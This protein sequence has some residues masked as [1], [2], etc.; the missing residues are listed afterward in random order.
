MTDCFPRSNIVRQTRLPIYSIFRL[1]FSHTRPTLLDHA[2]AYLRDH[3]FARQP[4]GGITLKR[5]T[6]S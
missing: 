1:L 4:V 6:A 5:T 3:L 2:I